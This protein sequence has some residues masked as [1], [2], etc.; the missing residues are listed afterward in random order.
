MQREPHYVLVVV[1]AHQDE[2]KVT[3]DMHARYATGPADAVDSNASTKNKEIVAFIGCKER[4]CA[5]SRPAV[6]LRL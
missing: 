5:M 1:P 2:R 4:M 6:C 3:P